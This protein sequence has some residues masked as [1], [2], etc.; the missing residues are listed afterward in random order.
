MN[1]LPK[2]NRVYLTDFIWAG[3]EELF[4]DKLDKALSDLQEGGVEDDAYNFELIDI[5]FAA[6]EGQYLAIIIY[7]DYI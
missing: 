7:K 3:D 4:Q 6:N 5:K 2:D 1:E